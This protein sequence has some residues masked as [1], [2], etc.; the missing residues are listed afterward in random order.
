MK[1]NKTTSGLIYDLISVGYVF[2]LTIQ[3]YGFKY[4]YLIL[5]II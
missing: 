5:I 1:E 4:S 2:M 3:L